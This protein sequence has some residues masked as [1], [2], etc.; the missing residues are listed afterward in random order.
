L[1]SES[2]LAP[3]GA[4]G[5]GVLALNRLIRDHFEGKA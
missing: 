3:K 1:K 5:W 2:T 4:T